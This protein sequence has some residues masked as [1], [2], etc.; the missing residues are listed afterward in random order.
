MQPTSE[1]GSPMADA[2]PARTPGGRR[3]FRWGYVSWGF[4]CLM[5]SVIGFWPSY[6]AP[7]L[8][9]KYTSPSAMMTW[10]IVST[11]LWLVLLILQPLLVQFRRIK[12]HR[13]LG[14]FGAMVAV[15]VI[16]TG[17]RVQVD[18]M[19]RYA[20]NGDELNAVV[21]PLIR[22]TLLG[23]FAVCVALA[24][25]VRHRP[26][27]HKRLLILG[28][29]P[30]LQSAFDRMGA[31]VFNLPEIRGMFAAFGHIGLITVFL[32]WDRITTGYF[33][34]VT[35]WGAAICILFYLFS[36]VLTGTD[37]WRQ[38]AAQLARG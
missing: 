34:P 6:V 8:T 18:V 32:I 21:I 37:W 13:L 29:F 2:T 20:A 4:I 9:A 33:H 7:L 5:I 23:G 17:V 24:V 25:A 31:N 12:V 11:G 10:H 16:D 38:L 30:L 15:A 27:W 1:H 26:Q 3:P 35:R 22:L 14:W 28:T 19:R 36:P